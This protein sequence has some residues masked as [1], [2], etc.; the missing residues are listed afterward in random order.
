M[1]DID[2][3]TLIISIQAV[4]IAIKQQEKMLG[5]EVLG[6]RTDTEEFI[7][8]LENAKAKLKSAYLDE[9]SRS[10]NL[11]EYEELLQVR[12]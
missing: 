4:E 10:D 1:A 9:C 3:S 8:S 12:I 11:P 6:D 5:A 7:F 2:S